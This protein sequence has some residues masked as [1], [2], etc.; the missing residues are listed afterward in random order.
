MPLFNLT[1]LTCLTNFFSYKNFPKNLLHVQS[2]NKS[3]LLSKKLSKKLSKAKLSKNAIHCAIYY[4]TN[5][6]KN[7]IHHT[8]K[9]ILARKYVKKKSSYILNLNKHKKISL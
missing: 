4:Q 3:D 5:C 7:V 6:P 8:A 1:Y 2:V 9:S